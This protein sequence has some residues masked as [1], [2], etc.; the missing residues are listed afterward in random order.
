MP[1][2]AQI[3]EF[4]ITTVNGGAR[5]LLLLAAVF[6]IAGWLLRRRVRAGNG[7]RLRQKW[8]HLRLN[9]LYYVLDALVLTPFLTLLALA[10]AASPIALIDPA[11]YADWPGGV[12]ALLAL[13][14]SD[15]AGYWRHRLM[16]T[17]GL[18]PV[19]AAHHSDPE[20]TWLTLARF[21]PVN[22]VIT[23]VI[24]AAVLTLL[25]LPAWAIA[26]NAV[27]RHFYGY[28]IHADLP[29]GYG[30][31][32]RILVSPAMHHWHHA[33]DVTGSGANFATVFAFWD[34]LFGT[35]YVPKSAPA[36]LGVNDAGYPHGWL[37]QTAWPL[38]VA[39]RFLRHA[40]QKP[41]HGPAQPARD[42]SGDT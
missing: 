12:V 5:E 20:M 37:G 34:V 8:P 21:H 36:A 14:A 10:I 31:V 1:D 6:G 27:V 41:G 29:L 42:M 26:L 4:T 2:A 9:L 7:F 28:F 39:G 30:P 23:T 16:H 32:G 3:L 11:I 19:H 40:G 35:W 38:L 18:W 33:R 24:S 17:A 13:A 22:R 25:G 15:F